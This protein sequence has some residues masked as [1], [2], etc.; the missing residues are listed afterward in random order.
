MKHFIL[1]LL[2][3]VVTSCVPIEPTETQEYVI[4]DCIE[5]KLRIKDVEGYIG[6]DLIVTPLTIREHQYLF[7]ADK[8]SVHVFSIVHDPDCPKC[9]N[10]AKIEDSLFDYLHY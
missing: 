1:L 8:E 3:M 4:E 5:L 10:N 9:K 7:V 6:S 2:L